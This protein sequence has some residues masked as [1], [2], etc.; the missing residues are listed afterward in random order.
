MS[1]PKKSLDE[2][3][4]DSI[5]RANSQPLSVYELDETHMIV[6]NEIGNNEYIVEIDV[7]SRYVISCTCPHW[8]YRVGIIGGIPCKHMIAVCLQKDYQW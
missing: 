4:N 1:T 7:D 5:E 2:M 3:M 8:I 6:I